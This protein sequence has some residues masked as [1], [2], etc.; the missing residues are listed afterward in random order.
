MEIPENATLAD[1]VRI[2]QEYRKSMEQQAETPDELTPFQKDMIKRFSFH[3]AKD[4][5][6]KEA[7]EKIRNECL[8]LTSY[9][10]K[11]VPDGREKALALTH[12]EEVMM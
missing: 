8:K 5:Q 6:T 10:N 1:K 12:L 7:H 3:P 4:E 2:L 11:L 9:I